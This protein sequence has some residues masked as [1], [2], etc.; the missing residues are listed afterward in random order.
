VLYGFR[1]FNRQ[2]II[3][4]T[5]VITQPNQELWKTISDRQV[6]FT[7]SSDFA[8]SNGPALTATALAPDLNYYS[9]RGGRVFPLWRDDKAEQPNLPPSLLPYLSE[10]FSENTSA[11]DLMAYIAA[12]AAHPAYTAKFQADLSMP[13]LRIPLTADSALFAEAAEPRALAA[14]LR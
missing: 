1:S 11:E 2:W 6:F 7:A 9:G 8:P 4:D 13:G 5:R 14:Y 10:K 12:V 3:P